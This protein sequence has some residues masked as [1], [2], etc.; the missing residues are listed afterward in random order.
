MAPLITLVFHHMGRLERN[1]NGVVKY[2]GGL[3]SDIE[4][5][6]PDTCNLS[7][8]EEMNL[9]LGYSST[10]GVYWLVP[11]LGLG[12]GL[13]LLVTDEEVAN[14]CD[15]TLDNGNMV[16]VYVEHPV[17]ADPIVIEQVV[18][19]DDIHEAD[20]E[21]LEGDD[22]VVDQ[23]EKDQNDVNNENQ[24]DG[25]QSD[26]LNASSAQGHNEDSN[27]E[28]RQRKG[29]KPRKK[30]PRPPPSGK[31]QLASNNNDQTQEQVR[32]EPVSENNN[33]HEE[34]SMV[35][36]GSENNNQADDQGDLRAHQAD[37]SGQERTSR[38]NLSRPP[39]LGQRIIPP[40][41]ENEA[42]SVVVPQPSDDGSDN[43]PDEYQYQSEELRTPPGSDDEEPEEGHNSR[44]YLLK[45]NEEAGEQHIKE[46][47][48][49][50]QLADEEPVGAEPHEE[51]QLHNHVDG[52]S[53]E[54]L[55]QGHP[56][57][58]PKDEQPPSREGRTNI[59][60]SRRGRTNIAPSRHAAQSRQQQAPPN[61]VASSSARKGAFR[62]KM[63]IVRPPAFMRSAPTDP[64]Q[65]RPNAPMKS[66]AHNRPNPPFRPPQSRLNAQVNHVS[67]GASS[68]GPR[69]P[70]VSKETM[71]EVSKT[72][73]SRFSD[74]MPSQP[75]DK[76]KNA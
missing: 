51:Q 36:P 74:F 65:G 47:P 20:A 70:M 14:M 33:E 50:Q 34:Q 46:Q 37:G 19:S 35:E 23:P 55:T 5:V 53:E 32:I 76:D 9:D 54:D 30:F 52:V 4:V 45:R 18:V 61:A 66:V 73:I 56:Q 58:Q 44:R 72:T 22:E 10:K 28:V 24:N 21:I 38:R 27:V 1:S 15:A 2:S 40:R 42:P 3:V 68:C 17:I 26:G 7:M 13:R 49:E 43:E 57:L 48:Q 11:G 8:V 6:N 29:W 62:T 69:Q 75:N 64:L 60:P 12:N 67:A 25:I 41:E 39:L 63:P 31:P 16:H 71:I 59:T